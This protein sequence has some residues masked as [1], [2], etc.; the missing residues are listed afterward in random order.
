MDFRW[1]YLMCIECTQCSPVLCCHIIE[2]GLHNSNLI[3]TYILPY[4][5]LKYNLSGNISTWNRSNNNTLIYRWK[6]AGCVSFFFMHCWTKFG[7]IFSHKYKS[8]AKNRCSLWTINS[9]FRTKHVHLNAA[10]IVQ[11]TAIFICNTCTWWCKTLLKSMLRI[12]FY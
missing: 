6:A 4:A 1:L 9:N 5:V 8:N 10:D 2:M 12:N 3:L 11:Y 7:V